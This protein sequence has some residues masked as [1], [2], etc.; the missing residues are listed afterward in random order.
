MRNAAGLGPVATAFVTT[1]AF[2]EGESLVYNKEC[3]ASRTVII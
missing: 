1:P 3:Q 2:A